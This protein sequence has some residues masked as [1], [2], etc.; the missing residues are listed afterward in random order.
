MI[1]AH[2][3]SCT[4]V[5][6]RWFNHRPDVLFLMDATILPAEGSAMPDAPVVLL[7]PIYMNILCCVRVFLRWMTVRGT[8]RVLPHGGVEI[9]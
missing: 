7:N 8:G 6:L 4:R 1:E 9:H 3:S 2:C 5:N